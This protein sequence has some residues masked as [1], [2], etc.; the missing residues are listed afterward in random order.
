MAVP[1]WADTPA[2]KEHWNR[3]WKVPLNRLRAR[4]FKKRLWEAGYLSPHFTRAE[5]GSKDGTPIP[6]SLRHAAQRQAFHMERYR[7]LRGDRPIH[8]LSWYRSPSHNAAVGGASQSQHLQARAVD[9]AE[10]QPLSVVEQVWS[11]GGIGTYQGAVR[12]ADSRRGAARW[13][14]G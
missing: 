13:T 1:Q 11:N 8:I 10:L 3:P 9:F 14:Y 5:A 6:S 2:L 4:K 12:H 7:H